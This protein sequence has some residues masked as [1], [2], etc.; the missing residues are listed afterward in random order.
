MK[1]KMLSR[2][3]L[4]ATPL[5]AAYQAPPSMDFPGKSSGVGCHC[6]LQ[7]YILRMRNK[8]ILELRLYLSPRPSLPYTPEGTQEAKMLQHALSRTAPPAPPKHTCRCP[9]TP[10]RHRNG[11]AHH[12]CRW[13]AS[14]AWKAGVSLC[15]GSHPTCKVSQ[16]L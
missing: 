11:R 2:V 3:Q 16:M 8:A 15:Q 7:I 6:L 1:V 5:T 13:P 9:H 4:L 12:Q 14:W 10:T